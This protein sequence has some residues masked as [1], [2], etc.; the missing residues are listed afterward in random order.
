[1][2]CIFGIIIVIG[3]ALVVSQDLDKSK[4]WYLRLWHVINISCGIW[5]YDM[6][7]KEQGLIGSEKLN[8]LRFCDNCI[9]DN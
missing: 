3:H 8:K 6:L 4:L 7:V 5:D 1:M 9:L 2:G